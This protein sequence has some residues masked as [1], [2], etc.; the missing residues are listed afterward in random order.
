M[1]NSC[2]NRLVKR[3]SVGFGALV[4]LTL[5]A[6]S[7]MAQEHDPGKEFVAGKV[8][9]YVL[10]HQLLL[11]DEMATIKREIESIFWDA[12]LTIEWIHDDSPRRKLDPQELRVILLPSDGTRWFRGPTNIIGIAPHDATGIGRNCF[13]FYRQAVWFR[14][15][16]VLRCREALQARTE[17]EIR[18]VTVDPYIEALAPADCGDRLASLAALIVARAAAH[19]MVHILLN[20]LDHSADGLMRTSFDISEWVIDEPDYFRLG[21]AE[22]AELRALLSPRGTGSR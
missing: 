18:G 5:A 11:S 17:A 6:T 8:V 14:Q 19:E 3:V 2:V 7:S 1:I 20:K 10:D 22:V 12:G 21:D 4:V 13:V 16:T 9:V 15:Q